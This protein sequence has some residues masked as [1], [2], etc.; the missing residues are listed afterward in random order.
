LLQVCKLQG[1]S[2]KLEVLV[3]VKITGI[4][5]PTGDLLLPAILQLATNLT[6]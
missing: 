4:Q 1:V 2:V 6:R 5:I 3:L